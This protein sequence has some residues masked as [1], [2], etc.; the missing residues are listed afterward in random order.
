MLGNPALSL[1]YLTDAGPVHQ[2]LLPRPNP[3]SAQRAAAIRC[4]STCRHG[5]YTQR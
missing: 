1:L 4:R 5:N 3:G 2:N